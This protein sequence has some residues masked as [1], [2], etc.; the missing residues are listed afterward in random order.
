MCSKLKN[1]QHHMPWYRKA[2]FIQ[3]GNCWREPGGLTSEEAETVKLFLHTV[4]WNTY[5]ATR[6]L[7]SCTFITTGS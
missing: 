3:E 2:I 7:P 6:T 1:I 5:T 4:R